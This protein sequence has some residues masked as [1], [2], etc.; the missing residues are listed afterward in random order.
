MAHPVFKT[1]DLIT[2]PK[3]YWHYGYKNVPN[4]IQVRLGQ[5]SVNG[6]IKV[7]SFI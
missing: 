3:W 5:L 4:G 2:P 1:D 7:P 6:S